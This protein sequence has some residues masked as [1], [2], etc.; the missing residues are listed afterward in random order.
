MIGQDKFDRFLKKFPHDHRT[1]FNRPHWTRRQFFQVA[2]AGIT[3]SILAERYARADDLSSAGVSPHNTARN[4]IFILLAGAPSHTDT[5]DLKMVDG[6]TPTS[7]APETVKGILWPTGLLPN[8]GQNFANGD[9]TIVRSMRAWALVHSLAQTW[10]QIGRNPAAALG[11]IAPN[12]GSVVAI[13]KEKERHAGQVFPTFLALNSNG[14]AGPGYFPAVYA[15]FKVSPNTKGITNTTSPAGQARFNNR[16]SL[17]HSLDDNLR[18]NSPD[19]KAMEDYDDFYSSAEGLMYN[20]AV[21]QAF[22]FSADDSARYGNTSLGNACLVAHHVL[23]A[24]QGTRFVQITSSDGW[25]MHQNIYSPTA[26]PAKG[27]I[28]DNA[29]S[30]LLNDLKAS[31]QL[32]S[33]LVVMAGEFGRTVGKLSAA[34]GRDH[35]VQQ[36][37]FFAGGGVQG[38][39]TIGITND[40]GSDVTDFGW[41]RDRY[42]RPEDVEATIYSAVGIDWTTVR[43][44]DPFGR[45]FEYVPFS[46]QNLYGPIDELWTPA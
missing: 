43:R 3:G 2:G 46:E 42:I 16:W 41:S 35:Y 25:D 39:R 44:D 10:T 40:Q 26:L 33:T 11:N 4:V 20:P 12:I 34:A 28:L 8:L 38:G 29:V 21:N 15:P 1:F 18:V 14:A 23:L 13:E 36:F 19:G 17:M 30:A 6:I 22:A 24:D 31:G 32:D 37:V 5:F 7:F 27:K 45:G 9:F